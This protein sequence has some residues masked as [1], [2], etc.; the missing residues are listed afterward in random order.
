L[1]R[2]EAHSISLSS[3]AAPPLQAET[4][5]HGVV[6]MRCDITTCSSSH[7]SLLVSGS[8]QTCFDDQVSIST[9]MQHFLALIFIYEKKIIYCLM[10]YVA[11]REPYQE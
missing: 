7:V 1:F 9:I 11:F 3:V 5:S 8:A 6:T 4:L 10:T 2:A